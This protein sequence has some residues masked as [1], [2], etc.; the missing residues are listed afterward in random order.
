MAEIKAIET[1]YNGYRFR[2]R[3]EAKWAV[4]FNLLHIKYEYEPEGYVLD[5]GDCYL[6][7]FYLPEVNTFFEVKPL[8]ISRNELI[9]TQEKLVSLSKAKDA[10]SMI[11]RGDPLDNNIQVYIPSI[12]T[13]TIAEFLKGAE[14]LDDD[15]FHVSKAFE[16]GIVTGD[17]YSSDE[18]PYISATKLM[19]PFNQV[20]SFDRIPYD[21]QRAARQARFEHGECGI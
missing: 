18:K 19:I 16:C 13:W 12:D 11:C 6:P 2:S 21:E 20:F 7:D 10:F 3:L 14:V 8:S 9:D 4:Y 17:R 15:Y 5:S 1:K